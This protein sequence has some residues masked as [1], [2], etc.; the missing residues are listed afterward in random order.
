LEAKVTERR[1]E[2]EQLQAEIK[3]LEATCDN[4]RKETELSKKEL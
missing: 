4:L 1:R 2:A 3:R